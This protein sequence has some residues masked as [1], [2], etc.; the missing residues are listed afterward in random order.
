MTIQ[1]EVPLLGFC[2]FS[3]TGKTTLLTRLIPLLRAEGLRLG[4]VKHAHHNFEIDQ[5]GKDSRRLRDSGAEQILIASRHRMALIRECSGPEREPRLT[6]L[7][8]CIDTRSLDLVLVEG[9]K[10]ECIAK[11][12]LHRPSLGKPLIHAADRNVIAVA[13]DAPVMLVRSLPLLDLNRPEQIL[14][15]VVNWMAAQQPVARAI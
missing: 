4:V 10:R 11:I 3:G 15:F 1:C 5:P 8:H 14:D 2:A 12:E 6:E 13:S 7:L 9:F